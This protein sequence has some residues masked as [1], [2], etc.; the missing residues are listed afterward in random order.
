[1]IPAV[2][3][4]EL[5]QRN[6]ETIARMEQEN[7]SLRTRGEVAADG[8]ATFIGSWRFIIVQSVILLMWM[9]INILG[10]LRHWDPYP[11][12]ML[13]LA[14]S[15]QAAYTGPILLMSQNRQSR[16]SERRNHL[17]LQINLLSEQENT[18][19]LRMLRLLCNKHGISVDHGSALDVLMQQ[20]EPTVLV[21]QIQRV[22]EG[23]DETL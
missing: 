11:F 20:V 18:E 12:V 23:A 17:D 16:L 10:W 8:F 21:E 22:V 2:T 4:D 9:S 15:F 5:T 14:L 13:N 6:V 3:V 7:Y 19:M 1:M